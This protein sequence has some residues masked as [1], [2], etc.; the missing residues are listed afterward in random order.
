MQY[1]PTKRASPSYKSIQS[2][3]P[4]PRQ[5]R[6]KPSRCPS[7]ENFFHHFPKT[8]IKYF[9]IFV[10]YFA[11]EKRSPS[12]AAFFLHTNEQAH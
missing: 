2:H 11:E 4:H 12:V 1:A 7:G 3:K 6:P 9:T 10:V 8:I 5:R